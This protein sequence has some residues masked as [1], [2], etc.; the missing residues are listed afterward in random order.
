[1]QLQYKV[2]LRKYEIHYNCVI[3]AIDDMPVFHWISVHFFRMNGISLYIVFGVSCTANEAITRLNYAP[4]TLA[5]NAS[6]A[7]R[8]VQSRV[9]VGN[10][11]GAGGKARGACERAEPSS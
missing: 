9:C 4:T 6:C 7:A 5:C 3:T 2:M 10:Q 11:R 1:M 8:A